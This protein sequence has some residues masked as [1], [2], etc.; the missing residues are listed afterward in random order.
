MERAQLYSGRTNA[1]LTSQPPLPGQ[2]GVTKATTLGNKF[3]QV[4]SCRGTT[5]GP[6]KNTYNAQIIDIHMIH[7]IYIKNII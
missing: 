2:E 4:R 1:E 3:T 6:I 5:N 7:Y